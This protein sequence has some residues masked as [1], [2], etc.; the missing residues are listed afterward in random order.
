[1]KGHTILYLLIAMAIIAAA[2]VAMT[3]LIS[4]ASQRENRGADA[5][6]ETASYGNQIYS[7]ANSTTSQETTENLASVP[8]AP[9]STVSGADETTDYVVK[10]FN[11]KIGVFIKDSE[12]PVQ[13]LDVP[14]D[15]LPEQDRAVL[16]AG[17]TVTGRE[18]LRKTLEDYGS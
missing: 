4:P 16:E 8:S 6:P 14:V 5:V 13:T 7:T 3:Y 15:T 17:I 2:V 12:T 1:M 11:G 9:P 18:N 10:A